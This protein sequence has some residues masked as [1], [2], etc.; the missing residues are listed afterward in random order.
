[1]IVDSWAAVHSSSLTLLSVELVGV[2]SSCSST[3]NQDNCENNIL[4]EFVYFEDP[5]ADVVSFGQE[6][7]MS[8]IGSNAAGPCDLP[9]DFEGEE[10]GIVIQG[11][12]HIEWADLDKADNAQR[13]LKRPSI[14]RFQK[15]KD[16]KASQ[17][18][19]VQGKKKKR[20]RNCFVYLFN[21]FLTHS[22][23]MFWISFWF[24]F[25]LFFYFSSFFLKSI[26]F[27]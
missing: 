23:S 21:F 15:A 26:F 20:K 11:V 25:F 4:E 14:D 8:V 7:Q 27:V 2:P 5:I 24:V 10:Y 18:K 1:V 22:E 12:L 17:G 19:V 13:T 16:Q 3:F 6:F 9:I